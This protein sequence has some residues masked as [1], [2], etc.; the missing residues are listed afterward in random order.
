MWWNEGGRQT[1][2]FYKQKEFKCKQL[3][4]QYIFGKK[5]KKKSNF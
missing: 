2:Q 1:I 4:T 3:I 5:K